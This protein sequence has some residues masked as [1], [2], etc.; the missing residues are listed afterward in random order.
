MSKPAPNDFGG[1]GYE[2]GGGNEFPEDCPI[3]GACCANEACVI[4]T[5]ALCASMDGTYQGDD[6][7]CD[8]EMC[9][10]ACPADLNH[11]GEVG[12]FDLAL[13]L[14]AWGLCPK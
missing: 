2:D 5:P 1:S 9:V 11:D 4:L 13:L 14:G 7:E 3:I 6:M 8:A 12:P 10:M